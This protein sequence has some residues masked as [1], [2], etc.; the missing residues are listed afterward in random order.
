[1]PD[2]LDLMVVSANHPTGDD[3]NYSLWGCNHFAGGMRGADAW[4]DCDA[5]DNH[6]KLGKRH[7]CGY[8]KRL[9][10]DPALPVGKMI[11]TGGLQQLWQC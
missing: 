9:S 5:G 11:R 4:L 3:V 10:E 2:L 1:M 8:S 7:N 6:D